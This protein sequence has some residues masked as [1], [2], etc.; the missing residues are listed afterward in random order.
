MASHRRAFK[1]GCNGDGPVTPFNAAVADVHTTARQ[2]PAAVSDMASHRRA[3]KAGC[4]GD[5]PVTPFNAAVADVHTTARQGPAAADSSYIDAPTATRM[6]ASMVPDWW[7]RLD[8]LLGTVVSEPMHKS[9]H[10]Q[11]NASQRT[12]IQTPLGAQVNPPSQSV[13]PQS[14]EESNSVRTK[15]RQMFTN[16]SASTSTSVCAGLRQFYTFTTSISVLIT[17]RNVG[18]QERHVFG[19]QIDHVTAYCRIETWRS[20]H[21]EGTGIRSK[22][23]SVVNGDEHEKVA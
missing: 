4:N 11:V 7:G 12:K 19:Y 5:G 9:T 18:A 10:A 15:M 23:V 17:S 6:V 14:N 8:R 22:P 1:A 20:Q 21:S 3:F 16:L 13:N 2:G